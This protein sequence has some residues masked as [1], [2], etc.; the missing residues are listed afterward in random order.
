MVKYVNPSN[1][2]ISVAVFLA[3]DYYD[4]Q[5]DP[6]TISVTSLLKPVRQLILN[7]RVDFDSVSTPLENLIP[8]RIGSA[9]HDGFEKAW[10]TNYQRALT[11]LGYPQKVIDAVVINPEDGTDLTGKYPIYLEVRNS[12]EI[13]GY[14]ITGKC[15]FVGDGRVEDFKTT[16][17]WSAI[18]GSKDTDY[19]LQ[20]SIYRW[21]RPDVITK[22]E[23]AIQRV[24]T[25][26]SASEAMRNSRY[27]QKRIQQNIY[28]LMSLQETE[29]YIVNKLKLIDMYKD[30]DEA[31]IPLCSDAELW[32]SA[33]A[34]KY[35]KN[36]S[37]TNR[38]TA[39]FD[40]RQEAMVRFVQDGSVGLVKEVPGKVKACRYCPAFIECSQKDTY[41]ASGELT[42]D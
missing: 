15:D 11:D 32:R 25:D 35:Y 33:P 20:G 42:L 2:P 3:S 28:K 34:F 37:K 5:S 21:L 23:M 39:N 10:K 12:K 1:I 36:P 30:A 38:S 22:D 19:I 27:P 13:L 26:W 17:V 8:S 16:S 9:I 14:T 29:A 41:L 31:D 7:K 6:N 24:F 40:T 18:M 4:Y